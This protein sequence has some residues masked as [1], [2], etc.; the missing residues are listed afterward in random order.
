MFNYG[1]CLGARQGRKGGECLFG[2]DLRDLSFRPESRRS[3]DAV[4][5]SGYERDGP[6][7]RGTDFSTSPS[8]SLRAKGFASLEMTIGRVR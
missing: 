7:N 4:E 1:R 8:T 2:Q 6:Y 3:R 5:E